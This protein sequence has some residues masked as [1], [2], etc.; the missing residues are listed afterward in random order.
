MIYFVLLRHPSYDWWTRLLHIINYPATHYRSSSCVV[1]CS[2][3]KVSRA[4]VREK[5]APPL[6]MGAH[7]PFWFLTLPS[8]ISLVSR[9][10]S[11]PC[12]RS[13]LICLRLTRTYLG[14][15]VL[16]AVVGLP[17]IA[18]HFASKRQLG[19]LRLPMEPILTRRPAF[20][21][22]LL[23]IPNGAQLFSSCGPIMAASYATRCWGI[24]YVI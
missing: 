2:L 13:S 21:I 20:R 10:V 19:I 7:S 17:A 23:E 11:S 16:Q 1:I 6:I 8:A 22:D 12:L 18:T 9:L 15:L 24:R 14:I 3:G 4:H 5:F